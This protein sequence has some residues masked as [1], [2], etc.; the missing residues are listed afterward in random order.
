MQKLPYGQITEAAFT[1][2]P[3]T[4]LRAKST[5]NASILETTL[6]E[7]AFNDGGEALADATGW[8]YISS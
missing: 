8:C 7:D 1:P 3:S 4:L 2:S 5:S 6:Q